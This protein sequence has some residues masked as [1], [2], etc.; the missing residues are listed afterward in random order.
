[1]H[2]DEPLGVNMSQ[3]RADQ[4][5]DVAP[6]SAKALVPQDFGHEGDPAIGHLPHG[7]ARL[8]QWH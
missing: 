3:I 6:L 5:A 8:R 7:N 2:P 4:R 1:M